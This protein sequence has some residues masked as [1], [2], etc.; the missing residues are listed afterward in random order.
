VMASPAVVDTRCGHGLTILLTAPPPPPRLTCPTGGSTAQTAAW[1]S[2]PADAGPGAAEAW[3]AARRPAPDLPPSA[4][5][6]ARARRA[7]GAW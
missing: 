7:G 5:R 4:G 2:P 3:P 1:G 6:P